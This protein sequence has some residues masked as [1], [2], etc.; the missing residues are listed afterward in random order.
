MN[1]RGQPSKNAMFRVKKAATLLKTYP[2]LTCIAT[3][4]KP[5]FSPISEGEAMKKVLVTECGIE[6]KRVLV[7]NSARNTIENFSYSIILLENAF[8]NKDIR[9]FPTVIVTQ[10]FHIKRSLFLASREGFTNIFPAPC[11][12]PPLNIPSSYFR[13]TLA[14]IKLAFIHP[15]IY[16]KGRSE[17]LTL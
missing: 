16:Q 13:E 12:T 15:P 5:L 4:G 9:S 7:E 17:R 8:D 6:S 10:D 11:K 1:D 3:G 2:N 14:Y